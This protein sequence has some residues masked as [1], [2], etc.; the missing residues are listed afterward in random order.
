MADAKGIKMGQGYV[1]LGVDRGPLDAGL[2]AAKGQFQAWGKGIA[3]LGAVIAAGG[4]A[5]AAPFLS[6][7]GDFM[8]WGSEMRTT[9]RMTAMSFAEA[10]TAMD[11]FRVS[12]EELTASVAK[13]DEFL[14]AASQG[15][16]AATQA[17]SQMGL[18]VAELMSM[19]QG[20]R[21]MAFADGLN[22]V[23]NEAERIALQRDVF[24]R[25]GLALNIAGGAAGVRARADRMDE[26]EGASGG[27]EA[28]NAAIALGRAKSEMATVTKSIFQSLAF[29]AAPVM[30]EFFQL[31]TKIAIAV[32][33]WTDENR[34][35]LTTIFY[36]A[37]KLILLGSVIGFLGGAIYAAS[38][39][40]TFFQ[41]AI[42]IVGGVLSWLGGIV[43]GVVS[44]AFW[45][46]SASMAV[47]GSGFGVLTLAS[48]LWGVATSVWTGIVWA[49]TTLY[50]V[51][52][53][54]LIPVFWALKAVS[55]LWGVGI[56]IQTAAATVMLLIYKAAVFACS[57]AY[58]VYAAM[59]GV[60]TAG[61]SAFTV[62]LIA[63][64]I[65]ENLVSLGLNLIISGIV[66]LVMVMIGAV[67]LFAIATVSAF[68][69]MAAF[70]S[71]RTS[72]EGVTR[73]GGGLRDMIGSLA[74]SVTSM[75]SGIGSAFGS[76]L[77]SIMSYIGQFFTIFA[78]AASVAF[79]QVV[80][81]ALQS[82]GSI[83]AAF[84]AGEWG[85]IWDILLTTAQ[86]AWIRLYP[87]VIS[88]KD[89]MVDLFRDAWLEVT[90]LGMTAWHKIKEFVYPI[91]TRMLQAFAI[92]ASAIPGMEDAEQRAQA[93]AG[94]MVVLPIN[95]QIEGMRRQAA[96][97]ALVQQGIREE[98]AQAVADG[99]QGEAAR[100]QNELDGL[101]MQAW[102]AQQNAIVQ[103]E[104]AKA[105]GMP[106]M[107]GAPGGLAGNGL[108]SIGSFSRFAAMGW[109]G[110]GAA[111]G[112]TDAERNARLAAER[113][114]RLVRLAERQR[115]VVMQ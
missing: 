24:G 26:L 114:E 11:G 23:G 87:A 107:P 75:A 7:M 84:D 92:T 1:S 40:F 101:E 36:V 15:S 110:A 99:D 81:V 113:L 21:M 102:F 58:G 14:V 89:G 48:F 27:E 2:E 86:L 4:A 42:A 3:A 76:A 12:G 74:S 37:D 96:D 29:A 25:G 61:T 103:R 66:A 34:P 78:D 51:A 60:A 65:W 50:G 83:K 10:D 53:M 22:R 67:A 71:I 19:S 73:A 38:Y 111:S 39:A 59:T 104:M 100:L 32:R 108:S 6:G 8:A 41:G 46:L 64:W 5:V 82:A 88:F 57:L 72:A 115:G 62:S 13:M 97:E 85:L 63:A 30:Q 45:I 44:V 18:S 55:F 93:M 90:I 31:A 95:G 20:D 33:Q 35:L 106:G 47:V 68:G 105:G 91:L 16:A 94:R 69:L 49:A 109:T 9:M 54:A 70:F 112:E 56:A 52:L 43:V 77:S 79:E 28:F 98:L 80:G 17:L